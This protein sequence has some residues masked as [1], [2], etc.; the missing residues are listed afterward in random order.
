VSSGF[1]LL[2]V[3]PGQTVEQALAE[4]ENGSVTTR[5]DRLQWITRI[6]TLLTD[7]QKLQLEFDDE[8]QS[9]K[10]RKDPEFV[11]IASYDECDLEIYVFYHEISVEVGTDTP[12]ARQR[13]TTVLRKLVETTKFT[14]YDQ[15]RHQIV[16]LGKIQWD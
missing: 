5:K 13:A 6:Q 15:T 1:L 14:V 9:V 16:D 3:A 8:I 2:E 11:E 7:D 4:L 12:A 10:G